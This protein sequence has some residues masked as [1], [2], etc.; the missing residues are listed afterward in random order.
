MYEV[1]DQALDQFASTLDLNSS[2]YN[3]DLMLKN[4][5][6]I[7]TPSVKSVEEM[8]FHSDKETPVFRDLDEELKY[9]NQPSDDFCIERADSDHELNEC[10]VITHLF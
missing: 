8:S 5:S 2:K 10:K 9:K 6:S 1:A 7:D 4:A 3:S